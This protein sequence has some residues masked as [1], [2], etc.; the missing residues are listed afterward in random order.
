MGNTIKYDTNMHFNT[1]KTEFTAV[2]S[3]GSNVNVFT[4]T[5]HGLEDATKV[6]YF[7][8]AANIAGLYHKEIY[9]GNYF[10]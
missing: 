6:M 3:V 1:K 9:G 7:E 2:G 4:K 10:S 5:G 8:G